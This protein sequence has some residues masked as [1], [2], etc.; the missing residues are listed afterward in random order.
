MK[1][2]G[3]KQKEL[4]RKQR[5][6]TKKRREDMRKVGMWESEEKIKEELGKLNTKKE[7]LE[8]IFKKNYIYKKCL[9]QTKTIKNCCSFRQKKRCLT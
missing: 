7:K 4:F 9:K 8:N 5:F 3:K 6:Q 2:D 1:K